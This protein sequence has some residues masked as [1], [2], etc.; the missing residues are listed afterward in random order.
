MEQILLAYG[1]PKETVAAKR[2]SIETPK[3]KYIH[4]IETQNTST[5]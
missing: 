3:W 5:L 4:Q 2:F 1:L